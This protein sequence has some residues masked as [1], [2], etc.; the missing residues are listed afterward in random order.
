MARHTLLQGILLS[1]AFLL[2]YVQCAEAKH[3]AVLH[4]FSGGSGDGANPAGNVTFDSSGNLFGTTNLGGS[5]NG[6]TIYKIPPDH[7]ETLLHAFDG[8]S[9]GGEPEA[10]VT[11]NPSTGDLYGTTTF[12]G[13]K[14][15]DHGC[16]VLYR[17]G[18]DGSYTVLMN[19]NVGTGFWPVGQ[20]LRDRKGNLFGITTGGGGEEGTLFEYSATG[21]FTVL[22]GFSQDAGWPPQGDLI[23]DRA[24]NLYG[25]TSSGGEHQSGTVYEFTANGNYQTLYSFTGGADGSS[26]MGGLARDKA[27]NR[28]GTTSPGGSATPYG[29]VYKLTPD[30]TLTTLDA[31]NGGNDGNWPVGNLLYVGSR[32]YGTTMQ[33]GTNRDGVVYDVAA[34]S[35]AETVVHSFT[36]TDGAT[37]QAGLTGN[38]RFLFG[39]ASAGG[40]KNLGVVFSLTVK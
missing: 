27:G 36:G 10:G 15:C 12:G 24:G 14:Y 7:T 22:Y 40:T 26:P 9:G 18:M 37:P 2:L 34:S 3:F 31:F 1:A 28:F 39:T 32:L 17:L 23:E 29:S 4:D 8:K 35:G 30:G 25:V 16:G 20:L 13:K 33:G 19:F 5:N 6:G 11:I 38:G 21:R